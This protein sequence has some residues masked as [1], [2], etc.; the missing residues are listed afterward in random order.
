[1][2]RRICDVET[3]GDG[4]FRRVRLP[5]QGAGQASRTLPSHQPKAVGA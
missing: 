5:A 2:V 1:M 3:A 4:G